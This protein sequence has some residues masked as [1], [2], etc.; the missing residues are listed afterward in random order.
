MSSIYTNLPVYPENKNEYF[1][2]FEDYFTYALYN[3]DHELKP[4]YY[5]KGYFSTEH[6]Y[7]DGL[8]INQ[9]W[10]LK[11]I[12]YEDIYKEVGVIKTI[13]DLLHLKGKG[14]LECIHADVWNYSHSRGNENVQELNEKVKSHQREVLEYKVKK[15]SSIP[16]AMFDMLIQDVSNYIKFEEYM[17]NRESKKEHS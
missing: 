11:N 16:D 2:V 12:E 1:N 15:P 4:K 5:R 9:V 17:R 14:W 7:P 13:N 6:I 3:P 8:L 10:K